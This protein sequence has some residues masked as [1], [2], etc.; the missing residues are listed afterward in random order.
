VQSLELI[1]A[2]A[3][4]ELD[5]WLLCSGR[6]PA[7]C[8]HEFLMADITPCIGTSVGGVC[9]MEAKTGCI[10]REMRADEA[11][12]AS[13]VTCALHRVCVVTCLGFP[14]RPSEVNHMLGAKPDRHA[15][16]RRLSSAARLPNAHDSTRRTGPQK[17]PT[18]AQ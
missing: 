18:S 9:G 14:I 8:P 6:S 3:A 12:D 4:D 5:F 17:S 11:L 10:W 1:I 7:L 15:L 2:A 13:S 16:D